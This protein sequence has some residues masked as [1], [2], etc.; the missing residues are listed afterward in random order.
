MVPDPLGAT[1]DGRGGDAGPGDLRGGGPAGAVIRRGFDDVREAEQGEQCDT[2]RGDDTPDGG[3]GPEQGLVAP[4]QDEDDR[5][6][7]DEV[8]VVRGLAERGRDV[9]GRHDLGEAEGELER[10]EVEHSEGAENETGDGG[11][12]GADP[13]S[14]GPRGA[15]GGRD[16]GD[17]DQAEHERGVEGRGDERGPGRGGEQVGATPGENPDGALSRHVVPQ[18]HVGSTRPR[19]VERAAHHDRPPSDHAVRRGVAHREGSP[20]HRARRQAHDGGEAEQ[21]QREQ[22]LVD[23]RPVTAERGVN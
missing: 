22:R 18:Q 14:E 12:V 11:A 1:V 9:P 2:D 20:Q 23:E 21:H 5:H 6:D 4:G 8:A 15:P 13:V 10:G 7:R 16:P 3:D 17:E 19:Q